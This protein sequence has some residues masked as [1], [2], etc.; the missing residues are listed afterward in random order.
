M[1][2]KHFLLPTDHL[3]SFVLGMALSNFAPL[4][5]FTVFG[6]MVERHIVQYKIVSVLQLSVCVRARPKDNDHTDG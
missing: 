1:A 4:V 5:T 2:P 6:I 3:V